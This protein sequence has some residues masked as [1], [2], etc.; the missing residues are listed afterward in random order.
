MGCR[1][2]SRGSGVQ[3]TMVGSIAYL[4]IPAEIEGLENGIGSLCHING[5]KRIADQVVLITGSLILCR[6][7]C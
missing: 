5:G 7:P 1:S 3:M 6:L 4:K 2:L